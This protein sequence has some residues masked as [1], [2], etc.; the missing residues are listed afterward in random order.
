MGNWADNRE[1]LLPIATP[2]V[3]TSGAEKQKVERESLPS[4]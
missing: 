2:S 1:L 3:A 4:G